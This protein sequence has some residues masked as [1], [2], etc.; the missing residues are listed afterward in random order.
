MALAKLNEH[1]D[2]SEDSDSEIFY[3]AVEQKENVS[4]THDHHCSE[5]K[6]EKE[7]NCQRR[8]NPNERTKIG[9]SKEWDKKPFELR[10]GL[11]FR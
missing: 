2:D 10:I 4:H 11:G 8:I 7:P 5:H 6:S 1:V 9:D 3:D